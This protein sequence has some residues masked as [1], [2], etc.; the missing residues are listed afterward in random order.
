LAI[1]TALAATASAG[2]LE[3]AGVLG[4]SGVAG[5]ELIRVQPSPDLPSGIYWDDESTLWIDGGDA[6][7]RTSVDG[8]LLERRPLSPACRR[9]SSWAFAVVQG[10]LYFF[11][12]QPDPIT[13]NVGPRQY[14]SRMALFALPLKPGGQVT[15]VK[16]FAELP[17]HVAGGCLA[18]NDVNGKLLFAKPRPTP[19]PENRDEIGLFLLD[20]ATGQ[21]EETFDP[22]AS[23]LHG[24][25]YD[26]E[27]KRVYVG[28]FWGLHVAARV[29]HPD[30][31]ETVIFSPSGQELAR[32]M[33]LST[34]A[35]PSEYRG[36]MSLAGGGLWQFAWYG[37]LAR[38]DSQL[39]PAPGT[40]RA[41]NLELNYPCQMVAP[42]TDASSA[43][44]SARRG[45]QPLAL[46]TMDDQHHYVGHWD[47]DQKQLQLNQ[48]VG[49]LARVQSLAMHPDGWVAV[50][51]CYKTL[52][53]NWEDRPQ[54]PPRFANVGAGLVNGYFVGEHLVSLAPPVDSQN[55]EDRAIAWTFAPAVG[56]ASS[57][58]DHGRQT[59]IRVPAGLCWAP[60]DSTRPDDRGFVLAVD[61]QTGTIWRTTVSDH[62]GRP[63]LDQ[64]K[65]LRVSQP[66]AQP[67]ELA[68]LPGRTLAI[69]DGT[70]V[71][72]AHLH[73]DELIV[74]SRL[75][76]MGDR[77][78]DRLGSQLHLAAD[79]SILV[80]A[81]T[82][83][84]RVIVYDAAS[85]QPLAQAG[86]VDVPGDGLDR[87]NHP[88]LVA[89]R[90]SR[91]LVYDQGNQRL[92]KLE[93]RP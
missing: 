89:I 50:G 60:G 5:A 85:R 18:A 30:V 1:W 92:I 4:N 35:I 78:A 53:W 2:S 10:V 84:H 38:L 65:P 39:Q 91:V 88:T 68:W 48:R 15:L 51:S 74:Q 33:S 6:I 29:T 14:Q 13:L 86:V 75:E 46:S 57:Q 19:T 31:Y 26:E 59:P 28:G 23:R 72:F 66:L 82:Q 7:L 44:Q 64:W 47:D 56:T 34:E 90:G 81:D 80:V 71:I 87:L 63:D 27:A 22:K 40:I 54:D 24:L 17:E 77:P 83:R 70:A 32:E 11:G 41:W 42:A 45:A 69:A 9:V 36:V 55:P 93:Y 16:A 58:P 37:F 76:S 79:Q 20:P 49:A 25:V 67:R 3:H 52:W 12:E 73:G 62:L 43:A 61:Q 8:R 21:V